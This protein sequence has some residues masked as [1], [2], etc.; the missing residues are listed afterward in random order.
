MVQL[1]AAA[2][3][4]NGAAAATSVAAVDF[5]GVAA[6]AG[7]VSDYVGVCWQLF[8]EC[9]TARSGTEDDAVCC[10]PGTGECFIQ[11][12]QCLRADPGQLCPTQGSTTCRTTHNW[13][14]CTSA[15]MHCQA[16]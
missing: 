13:K 1:P 5:V 4:A 6:D 7:A 3:S 14:T 15:K 12:L 8:Y 10:Q 11:L 9:F 16:A 2:A